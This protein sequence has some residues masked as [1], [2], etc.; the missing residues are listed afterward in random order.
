MNL[1]TVDQP[2]QR[3]Q[4]AFYLVWLKH[5]NLPGVILSHTHIKRQTSGWCTHQHPRT[6]VQEIW[7]K[8]LGRQTGWFHPPESHVTTPWIFQGYKSEL[9]FTANWLKRWYII[10]IWKQMP[11]WI[12]WVCVTCNKVEADRWWWYCTTHSE[13]QETMQWR[14][15]DHRLWV[16]GVD[17]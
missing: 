11:S 14:I 6:E 10:D 12:S 2:L 3:F 1:H 5:P 7:S 4:F 15:K 9:S 17:E 8:V 16:E 13:L